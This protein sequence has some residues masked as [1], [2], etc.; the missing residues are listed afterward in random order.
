MTHMFTDA[1]SW[2]PIYSFQAFSDETSSLPSYSVWAFSDE[3]SSLPTHS[4]RA[5]FWQIEILSGIYTVYFNGKYFISLSFIYARAIRMPPRDFASIQNPCGGNKLYWRRVRSGFDQRILWRIAHLAQKLTLLGF[6]WHFISQ[7]E[8]SHEEGITLQRELSKYSV[9]EPSRLSTLQPFEHNLLEIDFLSWAQILRRFTAIP[10]KEKG[11]REGV[12]TRAW[13]RKDGAL[14][15]R[16]LSKQVLTC[17][18]VRKWRER[19]HAIFNT[20]RSQWRR[21]GYCWSEM[22]SCWSN[23]VW[24]LL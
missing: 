19:F 18:C 6:W 17:E 16:I 7:T 1:T 3:T 15:K 14:W 24:G 22:E 2:L 9:L 8:C 20:S 5:L 11:F 21:N 23:F 4:V 13:K 10:R 12:F